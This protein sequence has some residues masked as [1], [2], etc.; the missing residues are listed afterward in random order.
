MIPAVDDAKEAEAFRFGKEIVHRLRDR[1][2]DAILS[3]IVDDG[4]QVAIAIRLDFARPVQRIRVGA[5]E[6]EIGALV[7][8]FEETVAEHRRRTGK[9]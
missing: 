3:A 6:D 1:K 9:D 8:R 2:M 7:H 4:R 5:G